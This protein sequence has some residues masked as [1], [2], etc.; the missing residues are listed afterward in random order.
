MIR[1]KIFAI[2]VSAL[3]LGAVAVRSVGARPVP[4]KAADCDRA[5]LNGFVD[6]YM[7]AVAA[8]DP[9][10]VPH[11]ASVKYTENNVEMPIG[12]GLWQTS[13]GWGPYK[14]YVDDPQTGQVGFLGVANEDTHLSCFAA[15]LKVVDN[16]VAEI[17]VIVARPDNPGS[18]GAGP[19]MGGP[20]NLRDKP[21]FSEDEPAD[22]R[23]SRQKL[24]QLANGYFDTIQLNTGKIYTTF[25]PDC[26]R[27]ENGF[28][29]AN[30]P[31]ATNPV[32]KMGC[33]AQLETGLLKIV[34]RC[35]DRRFVVDEQ[36][37]MVFVATFFDHNGTVRQNK[38]VDGSVRTIGPPFDRPYTFLIFELFKVKDAKLR[39][40]EAVLT[41]VPYYMPSPWVNYA[42]K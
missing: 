36:R 31:N 19:I 37:Q 40:I 41:T 25:D 30:N 35:R 9:S 32:A 4:A 39:Q 3:I 5:C 33:Q 27:M 42:K 21:L 29:T 23:V 7:A 20:E 38:L 14:V 6:Q 16:K 24:V 12:E 13:D 8:H 26:Q 18:R 22:Q 1:R 28:I 11:S 10:K 15:R 2:L 17:E 34:T